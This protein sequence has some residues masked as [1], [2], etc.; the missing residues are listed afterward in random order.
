[1]T[2]KE[3][4]TSGLEDKFVGVI[5]QLQHGVLA[6][7]G[8]VIEVAPKALEAV[9]AIK[10]I[11]GASELMYGVLSGI[12]AT[13]L[14][15]I[16]RKVLKIAEKY[17]WDHDISPPIIIASL[18]LGITA[19]GLCFTCFSKLLDVWNYVALFNPKLAIA[20]SLLLKAGVGL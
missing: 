3:L 17:N 2:T 1:M 14:F 5:D 6:I 18:V 10:Q 8:K 16:I 13:L 19:I 4:T 12:G 11:E 20:H 15:I 7:A 9:L